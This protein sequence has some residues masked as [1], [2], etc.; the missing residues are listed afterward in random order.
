M[1]T[2]H[3]SNV[4]RLGGLGDRNAKGKVHTRSRSEKFIGVCDVRTVGSIRNAY[5]GHTV[6]ASTVVYRSPQQ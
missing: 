5:C 6:E 3:Y 4:E 1:R 2:D